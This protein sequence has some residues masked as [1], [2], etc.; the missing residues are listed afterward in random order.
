MTMPTYAEIAARVDEIAASQQAEWA[1]FAENVAALDGGDPAPGPG[2]DAPGVVTLEAFPLVHAVA[3]AWEIAEAG[4]IN[5]VTLMLGTETRWMGEGVREYLWDGLIAGKAYV[6]TISVSG[7]G[8]A[9]TDT[10]E[11]A[12]HVPPTVVPPP[13][14]SPRDLPG[15]TGCLLA[16]SE[17]TPH[18]GRLYLPESGV[19][20]RMLFDEVF[21]IADRP[22]TFIDCRGTVGGAD[23]FCLNDWLYDS[24]YERVT[25]DARGT[26]YMDAVL[27]LGQT[28][29]DIVRSVELWAGSGSDGWKWGSNTLLEDVV[30]HGGAANPSGGEH[31]DLGGQVMAG[32]NMTLRRFY[33]DG[34]TGATSALMIRADTGDVD[35]VLCEFGWIEDGNAGQPAIYCDAAAG[36]E[37]TNA[38][39][40]DIGI[41]RGAWGSTVRTTPGQEPEI[42]RV[43]FQD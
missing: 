15:T 36:H 8:G 29:S 28:T 20:E 43:E 14:N 24:T 17:L 41:K 11:G 30:C 27:N 4:A 16:D 34:V 7:P 2:P 33:I 9:Q 35:Q 22:P 13:V 40:R 32:K 1:T 38:V 23:W 5:S 10:W 19:V 42:V 39:L 21:V 18:S 3:F 12:T 31:V 26:D 6:A 37:I 25:L